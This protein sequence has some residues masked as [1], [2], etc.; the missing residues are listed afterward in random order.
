MQTPLLAFMIT[1]KPSQIASAV[2]W[3]MNEKDCILLLASIQTNV[4]RFRLFLR[5]LVSHYSSNWINESF[6]LNTDSPPCS[7][8]TC[9]CLHST[10]LSSFFSTNERYLPIL[11]MP[12]AQLPMSIKN[13]FNRSSSKQI[14]YFYSGAEGLASS[15]IP[16]KKR[17]HILLRWK[18]VLEEKCIF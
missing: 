1:A 8:P 17:F 13:S 3:L 18:C 14:S 6:L 11:I 10:T 16:F 7:I 5:Y 12:D 4:R 9:F 15:I 2:C